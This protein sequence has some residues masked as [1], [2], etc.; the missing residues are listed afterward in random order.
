MLS[1]I[2]GRLVTGRLAFLLAWIVDVLALLLAASR[3]ALRKRLGS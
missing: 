2:V 1:R 3:A